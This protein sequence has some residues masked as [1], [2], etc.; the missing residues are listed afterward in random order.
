MSE[1]FSL[2]PV[3]REG[4]RMK[5]IWKF[6]FELNGDVEIQMPEGALVIH[7][8]E[9]YWR[10]CIWA[11]V[12]TANPLTTRRF[13]LIGTGNSLSGVNDEQYIGTVVRLTDVLHIFEVTT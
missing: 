7:V 13:R 12:E 1:L 11:I 3:C 8:G 6:P 10:P 2:L 5:M 9:Q 4:D